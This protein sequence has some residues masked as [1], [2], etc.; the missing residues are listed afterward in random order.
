M[1]KISI[2][3]KIDKNIPQLNITVVTRLVHDSSGPQL[4]FSIHRNVS[5][6][7]PL[8]WKYMGLRTN[9]TT[10][11][12]HFKVITSQDVRICVNTRTALSTA[13]AT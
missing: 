8:F 4:L 5:S 13:P 11:V 6:S 1:Y 10:F 7:L 12:F 3:Y 2:V 9:N